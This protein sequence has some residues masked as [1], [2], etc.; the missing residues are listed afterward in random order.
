MFLYSPAESIHALDVSR[1]RDPALTIWRA[2]AYGE[3]AG[4]G[5][6]KE[7]GTDHGEV[8]SM[9]TAKPY[10]RQ[11]VAEQILSTLL[12]EARSRGYK[13]VSLETGTNE[14]FVPAI[15]LYK[16]FGFEPCGPFGDYQ[17]DPYSTFLT[18]PIV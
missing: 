11:G 2:S 3:L 9:R 1:L 6:L 5:A 7:L 8:K 18:M 15:A 4:C 16:K 17:D 13:R 10:L 12:A 14:A